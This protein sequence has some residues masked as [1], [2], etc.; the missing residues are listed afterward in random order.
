M[1]QTAASPRSKTF[2]IVFAFA[3][4]MCGRGSPLNA[5]GQAGIVTL[6]ERME[7]ARMGTNPLY[8]LLAK[9]EDALHHFAVALHYRSCEGGVCESG[10]SG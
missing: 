7:R 9:A 1:T 4:S 5:E 6:R 2:T 8:E 10:R 3:F